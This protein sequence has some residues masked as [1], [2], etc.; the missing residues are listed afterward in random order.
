MSHNQNM[1]ELKQNEQVPSTMREHFANRKI[2]DFASAV[3]R[4]HAALLAK[5][6]QPHKFPASGSAGASAQ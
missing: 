1:S 2:Q 6:Q 5:H 3:V 4:P